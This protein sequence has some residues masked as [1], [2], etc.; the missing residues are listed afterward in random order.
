MSNLTQ[1]IQLRPAVITDIAILEHWDKQQHNIDADPNDDWNWEQELVREPVWREQL[2]AELDG[3]P[4]GFVQIIDPLEEDS[5]YWGEIEKN[6]RA[7]DIWMGE[8]N[9]IGKGYGS[10]IMTKAIERCFAVSEV[11]AILIDPLA[12]NVKAHRFYERLGFRFVERR[13]FGEDDCFVYQLKRENWEVKSPS[14]INI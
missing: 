5:H 1:R 12:S 13:F 11:T 4:I 6:L 7:I 3:R 10:V 14:S 8:S 2:I 9:D